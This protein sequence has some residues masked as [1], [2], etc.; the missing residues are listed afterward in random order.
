MVRSRIVEIHIVQGAQMKQVP[1]YSDDGN[2]SDFKPCLYQVVPYKE[3]VQ[4][5]LEQAI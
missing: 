5:A 1:H 2:S 3:G 4:K